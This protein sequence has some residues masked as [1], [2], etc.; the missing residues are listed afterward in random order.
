M[1][2]FISG[3][4]TYKMNNIPFKEWLIVKPLWI[5]KRGFVIISENKK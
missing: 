4:D 1:Q 5:N 2:V 3:F